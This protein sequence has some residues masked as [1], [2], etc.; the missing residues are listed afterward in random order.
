MTSP[1]VDPEWTIHVCHRTAEAIQINPPLPLGL[2]T[3]VHLKG[4]SP[5]IWH[6]FMPECK[7]PRN[8]GMNQ[9]DLYATKE[10]K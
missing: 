3:W 2:E 7:L 6:Q 9:I 1:A 8:I 10:E 5:L 4:D